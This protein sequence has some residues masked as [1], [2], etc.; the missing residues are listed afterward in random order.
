MGVV[1]DRKVAPSFVKPKFF[2]VP[3]VEQVADAIPFWVY[4]SDQVPLF[5]LELVF[6]INK[7]AET[8]AGLGLL[9][10][11]LF[12][13]GTTN[14]TSTQI[15]DTLARY[16]AHLEVKS[17]L[18]RFV[19]VLYSQKKH[20][21]RMIAFLNELIFDSIFPQKEFDKIREN[22]LEGLKV[23]NEK[24]SFIA[25]N[26]FRSLLF[27]NHSYGRVL[28]IENLE[29]IKREE[30]LAYYSEKLKKALSTVFL[31]GGYDES[32]VS[33]IHTTFI[34]KVNK[35]G[36]KVVQGIAEVNSKKDKVAIDKAVQSSIRIGKHVI[37]RNHPEYIDLVI[38]NEVLGG[39]FG[40]RLMKNIREEKGLTY[41]I[42]SQCATYE[43]GA[44][45]VIAADVKKDLVEVATEEVYKEIT[46]L[47]NDGVD[48]EELEIVSNYMAGSFLSSINTP[49][50]IIDKFKL[51]HYGNLS[52]DYYR[53]F[54]DRLDTITSKNIQ[55]TAAKYFTKTNELTVG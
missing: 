35:G 32:I 14:Y 39:Y 27:D 37:N 29:T 31:S 1:L 42:Y 18:D 24:T 20:G 23:N 15:Q 38:A 36:V 17:G 10:S 13:E 40:S 21:Q 43:Q 22:E 30:V 52:Y 7:E 25:S 34:P 33:S 9:S 19:V 3:E 6:N 26:K 55:E 12:T 51:V 8:I 54:Y 46:T 11:K 41:G 49:F 47:I 5:K 53:Q 50:D 2:Q 4:K 16:G 48:D 28:S 44:Y 45:W